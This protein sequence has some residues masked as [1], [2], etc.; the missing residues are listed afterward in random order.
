[1]LLVW[2]CSDCYRNNA[3]ACVSTARL[4]DQIYRKAATKKD[5]LKTLSA[6]GSSLPGLGKL[7]CAVQKYEGQLPWIRR[8]LIEDVCVVAM[9]GLPIRRWLFWI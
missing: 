1:L 7:P 5:G 3:A 2:R 4:I 6:I 8:N 9:Q